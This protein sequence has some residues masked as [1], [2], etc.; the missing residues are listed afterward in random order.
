MV[1]TDSDAGG[2]ELRTPPPKKQRR[3]RAVVEESDSGSEDEK[4]TPSRSR[5]PKKTLK[6][7][8]DVVKG[9][10][11]NECSDSETSSDDGVYILYK[12]VY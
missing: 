1:G 11:M 6:T 2:V 5:T 8:D 9:S 7:R 10:T 4:S 12:N 3:I